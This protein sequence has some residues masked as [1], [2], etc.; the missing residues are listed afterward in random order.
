MQLTEQ[1]TA[2][3]AFPSLPRARPAVPAAT[4][5]R[6]GEGRPHT[7]LEDPAASWHGLA[8]PQFSLTLTWRGARWRSSLLEPYRGNFD[9][10]VTGVTPQRAEGTREAS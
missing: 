2:Q 1:L 3:L 6:P 7:G 8:S 10:S 9:C 4:A 5:T